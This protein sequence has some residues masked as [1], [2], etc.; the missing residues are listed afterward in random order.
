MTNAP[1]VQDILSDN[2]EEKERKAAGRR[3]TIAGGEEAFWTCVGIMFLYNHQRLF[4]NTGNMLVKGN[5]KHGL[6]G[7]GRL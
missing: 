6:L 3:H 5:N 1:S 7:T 4:G 2:R